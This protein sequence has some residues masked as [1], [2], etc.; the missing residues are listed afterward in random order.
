MARLSVKDVPYPPYGTNLES[1]EWRM[2]FNLIHDSIS[3]TRVYEV[4]LNP[5]TVNANSESDQTFTVTGIDTQDKIYIN[6]PDLVAGLGIMW[7]NVN[8]ANTIKIRYRNFTGGNIDPAAG[9]YKI[10][11]IRG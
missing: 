5:T 8:A 1:S 4:S 3:Y 11:A 2:F 9:T 7:Y 10:I 6:P